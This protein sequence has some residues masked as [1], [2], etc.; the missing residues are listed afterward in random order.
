MRWI[1]A[2]LKDEAVNVYGFNSGY[3]REQGIKVDGY[4]H[5]PGSNEDGYLALKLRNEGFGKLHLV[6]NSRALVW[7]TD[8]R[9]ESD[10]GLWNAI[11]KRIKRIF[12][13]SKTIIIRSD[14]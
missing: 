8:R 10:G 13:R 11:I 7:T 1:N 2:L 9:I 5:P 14:L 6:T 3:R 12:S 4:R